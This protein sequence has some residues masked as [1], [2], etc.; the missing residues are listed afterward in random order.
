MLGFFLAVLA[1]I[2]NLTRF[3][4][5]RKKEE[6]RKPRLTVRLDGSVHGHP[7][8]QESGIRIRPNAMI[9]NIGELPTTISEVEVEWVSARPIDW[10]SARKRLDEPIRMKEKDT[11]PYKGPIFVDNFPEEDC[12]L[13][14]TFY[15]TE[16]SARS[17]KVMSKY[18]KI[19][20]PSFTFGRAV[21]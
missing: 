5:D 19:L 6:R 7:S 1:L 4:Y 17:N 12:S 2:L 16:D 3:L 15:F 21:S 11:V 10:G 18:Y 13:N 9:T 8:E 20:P 14:L